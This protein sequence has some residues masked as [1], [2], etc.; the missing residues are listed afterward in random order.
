ML[1]KKLLY[2]L[3]ALIS[4]NKRYEE[5]KLHEPL[6]LNKGAVRVPLRFFPLQVTLAKA[7]VELIIYPE[8]VLD[9][10]LNDQPGSYAIKNATQD[11]DQINGLVRLTRRGDILILGN[12]DDSQTAIL[13]Y[14]EEMDLRRL[15]I[16]HDGDGLIFKALV[17]D[18]EIYLSASKNERDLDRKE[19]RWKQ[20]QK[21]REIYAGN[22]IPLSPSDG[23]KTLRHVNTILE[24]EIYRPKDQRGKPGG[25]L[26][27]PEQVIPIIVGDLHAQVNN[28]LTLLSH[29][30]FLDAID[31][32]RA[33]LIIL[34][35]AIHS[36]VDGELDKMESS[37]LMMDIIFRLKIRYPSQVF[38]IRGNHDSFSDNVFKAG[39]AQCMLWE[40]ELRE[41]RGNDYLEEFRRFYDLLPYLAISM[42]FI[43]CHAAPIKTSFNKDMLTNIYQ[44]NDLVKQLTRNRLRRRNFPAGYHQR[45]VINFR[46]KLD[47]SQQTALLVSHSP[48]NRSDPLW[49]KAGGIENHH[50]VFSANIPWIGVFTR[51]NGQIIPLSY[52]QENIQQ[53]INSMESPDASK[54]KLGAT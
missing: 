32:N 48:L 12:H 1:K 51:I 3:R 42:D 43:A 23:L 10:E 29:N 44:H 41:K 25:I 27:I 18:A 52:Y 54:D 2:G 21:I 20:L 37:L 19:R 53:L 38:Y 30:A 45:D 35:D 13:N 33:V 26:N 5:V 47:V 16:S 7:H 14:P 4:F 36:E 8:S 50:I 15:Y 22:I 28:L 49:K 24:D 11:F 40:R 46:K 17:S 6:R 34:G 39:V 31:E 9:K